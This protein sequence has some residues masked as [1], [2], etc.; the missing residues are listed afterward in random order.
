MDLSYNYAYLQQ[1]MDEHHLAKKDLLEALGCQDYVSL[2]KWL[3]G[4]V[5]VHVTAMLRMCNFYQVPLDGFFLD[6]DEELHIQ[7]PLAQEGDQLLPVDG[8]GMKGGKGRGI[9]E[10]RV[11]ERTM[12]SRAQKM[13]VEAGLKRRQ[14]EIARIHEMQQLIKTSEGEN[15]GANQSDSE[16]FNS[17]Q[18]ILEM[19]LKYEKEIREL[20]RNY[21]QEIRD[22]DREHHE[23]QDQIRRDCQASF[24]AERNRL[25]D[26]IERQNAEL[27]RLYGDRSGSVVAEDI[28]AP[29]SDKPEEQS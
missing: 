9:V 26:I 18:Q 16:V 13:A 10:T 15:Q 11:G 8:Y 24:D 19:K 7:V 29:K 20:E 23:K 25:M 12:R 28:Q 1:F 2:N 14:D 6:S 5:P 4:K 27:S 22:L 3:D 17:N 21:A